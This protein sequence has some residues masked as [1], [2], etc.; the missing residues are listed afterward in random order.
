MGFDDVMV[1]IDGDIGILSL[2]RPKRGNAVRPQTMTEICRALDDLESDA[3]VKAIVLRGEGKHFCTGADFEFLESLTT[4]TPADIQNQIYTHFQGAA[5][6][7]F[8]CRKPTVALISGAAVTVGCELSLAC[9]FRLVSENSF[10]QETW[11]KLGLLPPLGGMFLL[12]RIVGLGRAKQMVLRGEKILAETAVQIGLASALYPSEE[13]QKR[14]LELA[15]ELSR[16]APLAYAAAKIAMH[17]GLE[18][19]MEAEWSSNVLNQA[20]LLNS[21]DYKEGLSA[22][23]ESRQPEFRGR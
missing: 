12:P 2:N 21:T 17:R 16:S 6:R 8:Y 14:G 20:L 19:S 5:R 11:I 18:T 22:V 3:Q 1:N 7:L 4:M 9:D 13:L 15:A 10:F 23:K